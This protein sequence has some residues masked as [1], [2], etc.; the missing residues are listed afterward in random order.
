MALVNYENVVEAAE[1]LIADG[2]KA[3]V[4]KVIDR[5]GGGSP[6]AV[7]KL[8]GEYKAGRPV[9]RVSDVELD[10]AIIAAIKRQMQAV[11]VDATTAAEERAAALSD[12]LQTLSESSQAAE[13]QIETLTSEK[14][15]IEAAVLDLTIKLRDQE[16]DAA[17]KLQAAQVKIDELA[18]DLG[19]ERDRANFAM[20][21]LGKAQA[22]VEAIPALEAQISKLLGDLEAERKERAA[23]DQRTAVAEARIQLVSEQASKAAADLVKAEA[24]HSDE[25]KHAR[26]DLDAAHQLANEQ[27]GKAAADLAKVDAR[28]SDE[29]KQV[30][31]DL[32]AARDEARAARDAAA[33]LRGQLAV[34]QLSNS[35]SKGV[36]KDPDIAHA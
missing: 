34:V 21:D 19:K 32:D 15:G 10:P 24:K 28:Y 2:Q 18:L 14:L 27:A 20:Q 13:Q 22:R 35:N 5:L 23:A 36:E 11:A 6:N 12:D 17:N 4:R 26:K 33:E 7:L 31:K 16:I 25:L 30:R 9:V 1:A 8:L 3:S 29:L